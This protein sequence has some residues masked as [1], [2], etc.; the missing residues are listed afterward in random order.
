MSAGHMRRHEPWILL[1][2]IYSTVVGMVTE[3]EVLKALGVEP[4]AR[5][6]VR[7]RSEIL[8]LLRSALVIDGS[9]A[10]DRRALRAEAG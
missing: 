8:A 10:G 9:G 2:T 5:S 6:L 1:L 3:V 4:T 7:R